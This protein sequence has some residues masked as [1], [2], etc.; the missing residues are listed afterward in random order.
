M[1]I[2]HAQKLLILVLKA[3]LCLKQQLQ[4]HPSIFLTVLI[5]SAVT[6]LP[7]PKLGNIG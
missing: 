5:R 1:S 2:H 3:R 4:I 7:E 6:G